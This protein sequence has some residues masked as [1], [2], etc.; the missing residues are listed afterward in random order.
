[1]GRQRL[2]NPGAIQ[3]SGEGAERP[4]RVNNLTVRNGAPGAP[5]MRLTAIRG[6]P[7]PF[8]YRLMFINSAIMASV[9]VITL[10]LAW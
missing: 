2:A 5:F 4:E 1:M 10:A 6:Q 9:V 7:G 8:R 3:A